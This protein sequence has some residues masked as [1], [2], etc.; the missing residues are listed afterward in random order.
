MNKKK[1]SF[2][3]NIDHRVWLLISFVT[4]I[5][6]WIFI[7]NSEGGK[8]IF[9]DPIEV[10]NAF[11]KK[12]SDGTLWPHIYY[13]LSR[14]LMGFG[15][16]FVASIPVAFLMAWY[17]PIRNLIEPWIQFVRNIPPLAYIP[18]VVL[19]AGVGE[20]SKV[21]VIFIAAFLTLVV[22]I[23]Q[24]VR[25]V[26]KTLINAAR[27]LGASEYQIFFKIIIPAST[28]F[29]LVGS[30]LGLSASLTTLIAAEL[31]GA[32]KGLG[33]FTRQASS[34]FMLPEMLLGIILIGIIGMTFEKIVRILERKLTGWQE[35]VK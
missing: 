35:T 12:V 22:T 18:L 19:G 16:A 29:I 3:S 10:V 30:R 24:G 11:F 6:I 31:T 15:L 26:D 17:E 27:V 28:P 33:M 1:D 7:A 9:A 20:S 25:G 23:Y 2:I 32:S 34:S 14:V 4:A 5:L 13:S 8:M 21:I